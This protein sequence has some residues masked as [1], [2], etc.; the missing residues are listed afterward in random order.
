MES[1]T[2]GK[3]HVGCSGQPTVWCVSTCSLS[4]CPRAPVSGT[5]VALETVE[6]LLEKKKVAGNPK[7][8]ESDV[9]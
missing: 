8:G 3:A 7:L 5:G 6:P 4:A 1:Q 9:S 2:L